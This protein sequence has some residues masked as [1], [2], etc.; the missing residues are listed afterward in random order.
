METPARVDIAQRIDNSRLG[1]FQLTVFFLCGLCLFMDGF[2]TQA[3]AYVAPTIVREW[4]IQR[5]AL[6]VVLSAAPFGVLIGSL[7]FSMIADRIGRRPVLIGVTLYYAILTL[8]TARAA[9]VNQL[10]AIRFIAGIGLGGI[11][12]NAVSLVGEYSPRRARVPV[13]MVVGNCFSAGA[14]IGGFVAAQLIQSYGWR[15]VFYFGGSIPLAIS[16]VMLFALPESLHFL[17]VRE[18]SLHKIRRWLQRID[19]SAP[20]GESTRYVLTEKAHRGVPWVQLFHEGRAL[21]TVLIWLLNFMNLLNLYFLTLWLPTVVA[22]I[23]YSA[24][25]AVRVGATLQLAG[26][27]GAFLQG[28]LIHRFGFVP[29][30]ATGFGLATLNIALIGYPG[31]SLALLVVVVS[32]AGLGVVGGQSGVNAFSATFYPTDIRSTGVGAGLGVGRVG[33]IVGPYLGG[34]LIALHWTNQQLF[35]ASAVP[36]LI[37]AIVMAALHWVVKPKA[38]AAPLVGQASAYPN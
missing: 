33:A 38:V 6:G 12:P 25:V 11:M 29:V 36:A 2:D 22:D 19:P 17:A 21:G 24:P 14:A 35:L 3:I 7:L 26:A 8:I 30:L 15:S 20:A 23:G 16:L 27:I 37:S 31:I 4:N 1:S 9:S 10:L 28:W 13:M 32:I 18:K 5:S 34:Q